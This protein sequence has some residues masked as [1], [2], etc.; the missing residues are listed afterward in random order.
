MIRANNWRR[1]L[2]P[3]DPDYLDPLTDEELA[4]QEDDET[5][6]AECREQDAEVAYV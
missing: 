5:W 3:R 2:D 6:L 4:E 1:N